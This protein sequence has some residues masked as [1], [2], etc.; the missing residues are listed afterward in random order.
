MLTEE[1]MEQEQ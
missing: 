1:A